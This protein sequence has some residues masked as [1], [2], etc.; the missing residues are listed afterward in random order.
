MPT[1]ELILALLIGLVTGYGIAVV[2]TDTTRTISDQE[3]MNGRDGQTRDIEAVRERVSIVDEE[4][5]L[6]FLYPMG[7]NGYTV[8]T[9]DYT[10]DSSFVVSYI[11]VPTVA[12]EEVRVD[13]EG[14][15]TM[16][17]SVY[18]NNNGE[19]PSEW[20]L[21][22]TA[23]SGIEFRRTEPLATTIAGA[24][25][26]RFVTDGLYTTSVA[27]VVYEEFVYVLTGS[28]IDQNDRIKDDFEP[29]LSSITFLR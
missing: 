15:P 11:L 23:V 26:L 19:K 18:K 9:Q 16:N 7:E 27:I 10:A 4:V 5:K 24:P 20:A 29:L 13:S 17:V 28:Y 8:S 2:S 21:S 22:H 12:S 1:K 14:P 25:A 6:R 3:M